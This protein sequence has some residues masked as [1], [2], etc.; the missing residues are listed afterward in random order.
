MGMQPQLLKFEDLNTLKLYDFMDGM[1][2]FQYN[3]LGSLM[4]IIWLVRH[5][6][7]DR[8]HWNEI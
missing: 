7:S 4:L 5:N 1:N 8:I 6:C 2:Y 3:M